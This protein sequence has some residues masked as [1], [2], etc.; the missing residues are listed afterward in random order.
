M[1]KTTMGDGSLLTFFLR[2]SGA[3]RKPGETMDMEL[4]DEGASNCPL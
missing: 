4:P 2:H 3:G 1:G